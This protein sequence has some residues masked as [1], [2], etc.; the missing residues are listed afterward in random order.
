MAGRRGVGVLILNLA[1][2]VSLIPHRAVNLYTGMG[3][4]MDVGWSFA[5][6]PAIAT[7]VTVPCIDGEF[8]CSYIYFFV[9]FFD[10]WVAP[11]LFIYLSFLLL[12]GI[13]FSA[14]SSVL[15]T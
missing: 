5:F 11:F 10:L 7:L 9:F 12:P 15:Q 3:G 2:D 4:W 14:Y 13:I 6:F 1:A 8:R